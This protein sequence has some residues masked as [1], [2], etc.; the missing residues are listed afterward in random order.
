M[1][2]VRD[3]LRH[4]THELRRA[5]VATAR[6][7]AEL[8]L[9]SALGTGRAGVLARLAEGMG[10]AEERAFRGLLERRVRREPVAYILGHREFWGRDFAVTPDVLIPRPETELLVARAL[11]LA[12]GNGVAVDVGTGSG[13]VAVVLAAERPGLRVCATDTSPAALALAR[14]NARRHGVED[15]IAFLF[16]SL[17]APVPERADL[18]LANLPYVPSGEVGTL[19]P[20]VRAWEPRAA[21]DGGADGLDV[22][23]AL[24]P[25]LPEKTTPGAVCLLEI[26]PR[27]FG[28]LEEA[29]VA[30][31]PGWSVSRLRDLSG[32]DRVAELRAFTAL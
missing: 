5:G 10:P 11:E 2:A 19:E 6:L 3:L 17:L 15:H 13:C 28:A 31:L 9:A 16:G 1:T 26:D 18:V 8:L 27:Q 32:R 25:Q 22:V 24:L 21:L 29:V 14:R 4:A 7:D 30:T 20:D 23:R 12:S